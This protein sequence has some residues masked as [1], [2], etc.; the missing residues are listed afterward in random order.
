MDFLTKLHSY[1]AS[2]IGPRFPLPQI[3]FDKNVHRFSVNKPNDNAGWVCVHQ[4][5]Y[6]GNM[7]Y[8]A[9]VGDWRQGVQYKVTSYDPRSVDSK[10]IKNE[11]KKIAETQKI[12]EQKRVEKYN[13]CREKWGPIFGALPQNSPIHPYL[14]YK[15]VDSNYYGR[16]DNNGVLYIPAYNDKEF[17]GCQRIFINPNYNPSDPE[18]NKKFLK[19][20]TFGIEK[21]GSFCPFGDIKNAEYVFVAEGFATAASVWMAIG[22]ENKAAACIWDTSNIYQGIVSIRRANPNCKIV[23]CAD[24]DI[25]EK[26]QYHKIGERKAYAASKKLSNCIFRVV[27]FDSDNDSWSDFNDLHCF[28]SLNAVKKQLGV[29]PADFVEIISLG[30]N[31]KINNYFAT[32]QKRIFPLTANDHSKNQLLLMSGSEKYWGDRYGWKTNQ[33]GDKVGP[34]WTKVIETLGREQ[35]KAGF[36]NPENIRGKGVWL[37]KD[38][39]MVNLGDQIYYKGEY[40]PIFNH[41]IDTSY[42]YEAGDSINHNLTNQLNY[43]QAQE[44]VNTFKLLKYK[45]EN[46]Y[47]FLLGW[48]AVAQIFGALDW[49][50]HLYLTGERGS[51]K[52]T[53][54]DYLHSMIP[55]S[56]SITD[57]SAAGIKQELQ[58]DAKAVVYDETEPNTEKD[59]QKIAEVT[60]LIRQC[61]TRTSGKILR[62]SASGKGI[63]Y[64]TNAIFCLGSI[65]KASF[66][67][68][69]DSRFFVIEMGNVKN[70]PHEQFIKLETS[71]KK[72]KKLAPLLFS[73]MVNQ[74]ETVKANIEIC[75]IYIKAQKYESRLADQLAPILAGYYSFFSNE[76]I[77]NDT[78]DE[79]IKMINFK[80]SEYIE[81]NS[82]TDSEKCLKTIMQLSADNTTTSIDQI[83]GTL[84]TFPSSALV[85]SLDKILAFNGIKYISE[86]DQLFFVCN[87]IHLRDKLKKSSNFEDYG[88]L[89]KRHK[90]FVDYKNG[91][92]GNASKKGVYIQ[93]DKLSKSAQG[94]LI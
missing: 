83:V 4:W 57:S 46:D 82:E 61:S 90:N 49:R 27:K 37:E 48:I 29:D 25:H 65:Q 21:L 79:L 7:Y 69:D 67:S 73:R 17:V 88:S 45:N 35:T 39:V 18:N 43:G 20:Y 52:S 74:C 71:M 14:Q 42:F 11:K 32:H 30:Y 66:S 22:G 1:I 26:P 16:I 93:M 60:T 63:S 75:K 64:N 55:I 68:A 94:T 31:G 10:F 33:D 24:R 84:R 89:L 3:P 19:M 34:N 41:D 28:D 62:G 5:D 47:I 44:I 85:E 92:I 78:I 36:F 72:V 13:Q 80:E 87:N 8:T 91:W 12:L 70:Q 51:G 2:K 23:I 40:R 50:P 54:L 81:T 56:L 38:G 59:R 86:K 58:N 9:I 15:K 76:L 6:K 53:I 77:E